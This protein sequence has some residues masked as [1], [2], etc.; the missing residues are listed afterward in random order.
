M[1]VVFLLKLLCFCKAPLSGKGSWS[2]SYRKPA[3]TQVLLT[4]V[5]VNNHEGHL[6]PPALETISPS[7]SMWQATNPWQG[8]TQIGKCHMCVLQ[9][10]SWTAERSRC[11]YPQ[12]KTLFTAFPYYCNSIFF[13]RDLK[14]IWNICSFSQTKWHHNASVILVEECLTVLA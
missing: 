6:P 8:G 12:K 1:C 7:R 3:S 11:S 13:R 5:T 4:C 2:E 14:T 10:D 9:S